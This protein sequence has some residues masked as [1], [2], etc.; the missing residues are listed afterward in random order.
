MTRP[1]SLSQAME[2]GLID[3]KETGFHCFSNGTEYEGWAANNCHECAYW[4]PEGPAG[5]YCAL[6]AAMLMDWVTPE[7]AQLFDFKEIAIPTK[8]GIGFPTKSDC[9]FFKPKEDRE[10]GEWTEPPPPPDPDQ[11]VLLADPTEDAAI[12]QNAPVPVEVPAL[13]RQLSD[14]VHDSR[15]RGVAGEVPATSATPEGQ[16]SR[17]PLGGER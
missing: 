6:E 12:I 13:E 8:D 5:E 14:C 17:L 11:F 7:L 4:P 15:A 1:P 3:G 10:D 2:R 16:S 9:R